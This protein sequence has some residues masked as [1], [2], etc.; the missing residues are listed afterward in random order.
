LN[1]DV[2]SLDVNQTGSG[3]H[4]PGYRNESRANLNFDRNNKLSQN[5]NL[6]NDKHINQLSNEA[7][8]MT[9]TRDILENKTF[10]WYIGNLK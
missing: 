4:L 7:S 1:D 3:I 8:Q 10:D 5:S 6:I 2:E 9:K